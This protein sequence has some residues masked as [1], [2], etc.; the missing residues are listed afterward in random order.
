MASRRWICVRCRRPVGLGMGGVVPEHGRGG[1]VCI[2]SGSEPV[3][4]P[5]RAQRP[6]VKPSRPRGLYPLKRLAIEFGVPEEDLDQVRRL[7]DL[8]I[9]IGYADI[10]AAYHSRLSP[11]FVGWARSPVTQL[12]ATA[13]CRSKSE[14]A[15]QQSMA[16]LD[17]LP[18]VLSNRFVTLRAKVHELELT[19]R[20]RRRGA[21]PV[22]VHYPQSTHVK[23]RRPEPVRITG[24]VSGGLPGQGRRA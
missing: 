1:T 16:N 15:L 13:E 14:R 2:G 12:G 5:E 21:R 18:S 7:D 4:A 11:A 17:R 10:L 3:P 24:I 9:E 19:A 8:P 6:K 22:K 20:E 23:A